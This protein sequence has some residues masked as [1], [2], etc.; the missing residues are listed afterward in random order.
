VAYVENDPC[1][2]AWQVKE[3]G[4]LDETA[5]LCPLPLLR[6]AAYGGGTKERKGL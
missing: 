3:F 5:L 6:S 4:R 1:Q 2:L